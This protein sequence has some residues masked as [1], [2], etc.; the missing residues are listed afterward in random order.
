MAEAFRSSPLQAISPLDGRYAKQF[1]HTQYFFSEFALIHARLLVEVE[2]FLFLGKEGIAI[3]LS[4]KQSKKLRD[5]CKNFSEK[6]AEAIKDYEAKVHHDVKAVELFLREKFDLW[7]FPGKE[8]LH[9]ALTS[10]DVNSLA[11][12]ILLKDSLH[13]ELLPR[14]KRLLMHLGEFAK[15]TAEL[16]ILARTHGQIA[17]PSTFGKEVMNFA[18]RLLPKIQQLE[19]LPIQAKMTGAV[20][21]FNAHQLAFPQKDWLQLSKQFVEKLGFEAQLY[22]T[23]ILPADNA[24]EIFHIVSQINRIL[25]N[26][27]Q[28]FWR[29][30]SDDWLLQKAEKDQV[31]SSTMPQKIN[32]IDFENSEGN[33]GL[34]NALL[35][36][37]V[38]KLSISRLQRDLSDS[39]VKRNFGVAFGHACLGYQSLEKGLEKIS[40]NTIL[41]KK[42]CADHPETL[43]EAYQT[44][45]RS[46]HLDNGYEELRQ[47]TQGKNISLSDL[48]KFLAK[49]N[50]PAKIKKSLVALT[51][52]H[53]TGLAKELCLQGYQEIYQYIKGKR[54]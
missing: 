19:S 1:P 9:L 36:H 11:Y 48:K 2:Y 34:A 44:V 51:P 20:G 5:L 45:L 23:Q 26:L 16:P 33:L 52:D 32:P 39:T 15:K 22:T 4:P 35:N 38:E 50:M 25:I 14:L 18:M 10:E 40:P 46:V 28:D 13:E 8:Y 31:G 17:V 41:L 47:L 24:A 30:I 12:A 27:N 29:Y 43:A 6:D 53:Y 49:K 3:S 54:A 7:Q 21:N 42:N 37:F